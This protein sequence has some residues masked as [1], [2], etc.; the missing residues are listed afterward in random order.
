[1]GRPSQPRTPAYAPISATSAILLT[2]IGGTVLSCRQ[3]RHVGSVGVDGEQALAGGK[4]QLRSIRR[5]WGVAPVGQPGYACAVRRHP[6][7]G[8]DR[9]GEESPCA[10]G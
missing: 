2:P 10:K 1:M 5:P 7:D 4:H 6:P 9:A 3:S 8:G